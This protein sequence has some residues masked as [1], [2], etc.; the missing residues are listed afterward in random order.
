MGHDAQIYFLW[1]KLSQARLDLGHFEKNKP[2]LT[3]TGIEWFHIAYPD[4]LRLLTFQVGVTT[5][6]LQYIFKQCGP[7]RCEGGL[8]R[9]THP[10]M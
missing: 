9:L 3:K 2:I 10:E 1:K 8:H 5:D 7:D 4:E 6:L